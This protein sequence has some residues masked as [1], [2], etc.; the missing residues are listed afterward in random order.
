MSEE[1]RKWIIFADGLSD[2]RNVSLHKKIMAVSIGDVWEEFRQ[3]Y[4]YVTFTHIFISEV[5]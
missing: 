3:K 4:C 1:K 5:T 2:G